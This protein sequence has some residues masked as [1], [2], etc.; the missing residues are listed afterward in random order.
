MGKALVVAVVID[1]VAEDIT[2]S[3][4]GNAGRFVEAM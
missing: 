1:D 2:L 3:C 4:T